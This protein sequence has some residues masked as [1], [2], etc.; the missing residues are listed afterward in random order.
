MVECKPHL[1][2][3]TARVEVRS[4]KAGAVAM[5]VETPLEVVAK[6][7][8]GAKYIV[9]T[10]TDPKDREVTMVVLRKER[11]EYWRMLTSSV[12]WKH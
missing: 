12:G 6:L 1:G 8:M 9:L 3:E 5:R 10:S 7:I 4:I 11:I 2:G